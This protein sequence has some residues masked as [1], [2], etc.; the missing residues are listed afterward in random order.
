MQRQVLFETTE[1]AGVDVSGVL[2]ALVTSMA[3]GATG[4]WVNLV[5]GVSPQALVAWRLVLAALVFVVLF[6][7]VR[8]GYR[9]SAW[10]LGGL[11]VAYYL[12]AVF[13]FQRAPVGEVSLCIG[14]SPV[15]VMLFRALTGRRPTW[16]EFFAVTVTLAG[17][18]VIVWPGLRGSGLNDEVR[19]GL[20]SALLAA[21]LTALYAQTHRRMALNGRA[22]SGAEVGRSA[23]A[24]LGLA[25]FVVAWLGGSKGGQ[26]LPESGMGVMALLGL[27]IVSTALPTVAVAVASSRLPPL[28]NTLMR[29]TTPLFATAFGWLFLFQR[30]T[31]STAYGACLIITGLIIL[32]WPRKRRVNVCA[33]SN[34]RP[35]ARSAASRR[36]RKRA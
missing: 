31:P 14:T 2:G 36:G 29:L 15:F 3:W 34:S 12:A 10:N 35:E 7:R 30:P 19:S 22:P 9:R 27:G 13:A 11:L 18:L 4:V 25:L 17:L 24:P 6:P 32:A 33:D 21:A 28:I 8:P 23:F 5:P 26:M 1:S 20:F 16:R